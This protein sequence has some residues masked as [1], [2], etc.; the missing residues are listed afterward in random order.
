MQKY[1]ALALAGLVAGASIAVPTFASAGELIP[2]QIL[3]GNPTKAQAMVSPDATHL[4]WLAPK[5]G[6]LNVW[7]APIDHVDQAKAVSDEKKRPIRQH[8]WSQNGKLVMWIN[9]SG[10]DENYKLYAADVASGAIKVLTP[11]DKT[12]V[13]LIGVSHR[14]PDH[15]LVGLNNRDPQYH[16]LYDVNLMTGKLTLVMENKE[17]AGFIAD[18]QLT[19]RLALKETE[20]GE[21][22]F[23]SLAKGQA[24]KL[25]KTIPPTDTLTTNVLGYTNDGK[26]LYS[27][28]SIGRDT[29]ALVATDVATDKSAIIGESAKADI[30]NA[31]IEPVSGKVQAYA[32][33]YLKSEWVTID[34]AIKG[35]L[36][37][38]QTQLAGD[39]N[40]AS[41]SDDNH[42]WTVSVDKPDAPVAYYLYDHKAAKLTKLF[43]TRPEL[44]G[45][46]LSPMYG[47][48]IK[49]VDGLTLPSYL[50]LPAGTDKD[51][52]G[53]PD[54]P[55][56]MVLNVHGG[57]WGRD[58]Y[59]FRTDNQWFANRGY[60]VLQVN[61]RGSTGF[62]KNFT[63]AG[64]REWAGK[65][66]QDLLD[67]IKWAADN[68]VTTADKVAIY[69]GS[70]G[71]YATLVGL[72]FTPKVFACGIDIVGPS[73]LETLLSTIPPYWKTQFEIFARRVGDP[74]TPEGK[75]LLAA[76][77]PLTRAGDIKRPLLIG[78][79]K[80]DPRVNKAESDQIVAAM[81]SHKIPVTYVLYPDEGHG[82][83]RPQNRISFNA[84]SEAFLS[85]CLGGAYQ[86]VGDDFKGA[87]LEV[88]EGAS[89][90]PGLA[91][92]M[93][94]H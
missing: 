44:V 67:A 80:N 73:N 94:K 50:T 5:D 92:A 86:P 89:Y 78:Q 54:K 85:K 4:S 23:Y 76:R 52:D 42:F 34:P 20:A 59:G 9:D 11:F 35:D 29:A 25:Y 47:I 60:A 87:S 90:V 37:L 68:K 77:S 62:G 58:S 70:Y 24:P 39:I 79:G 82:F 69:G 64:D 15:V 83:A 51:G 19:P 32:V 88:L 2:R 16:D 93:A 18:D 71:G 38:L 36:D 28:D 33:D 45:K 13:E 49:S 63:N 14:K 84:V 53:K 55:L 21:N 74:R 27:V 12:R 66:H 31:I 61:F 3:F 65:M 1:H 8:F 48:E 56:P 10:G 72:T 43:D 6:V 75:A 26:T 30:A 81:K 22:Q 7:V 46:T 40:V 41:R 57:P 17:W 91:D